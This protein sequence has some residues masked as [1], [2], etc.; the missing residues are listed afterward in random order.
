MPNKLTYNPN[1]RPGKTAAVAR[2]GTDQP[3]VQYGR[4]RCGRCR[5]HLSIYNAAKLCGACRRQSEPDSQG[6]YPW[7]HRRGQRTPRLFTSGEDRHIGQQGDEQRDEPGATGDIHVAPDLSLEAILVS[8][9][10][11]SE[12]GT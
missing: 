4:G 9:D 6:Y 8:V 12:D 1:G 5:C 11:V 7:D 2:R 3:L 10:A